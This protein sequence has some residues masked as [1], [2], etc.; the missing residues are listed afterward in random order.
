MSTIPQIWTSCW[1]AKLPDDIVRIGIGRGVPRRFPAGY[2]RF[3]PLY[4]GAWFRSVSEAEYVRLYSAEVLSHLDP[5]QLVTNL[6]RISGQ[7]PLA[8]LCFERCGIDGWCHRGLV[9]I[10]I[11]NGTGLKVREYGFDGSGKS[12]PMLPPG[13]RTAS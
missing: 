2:K 6:L 3:P 13:L 7:R 5:H 10:H 11:S 4:P 12:H 1:S 8:L 9:A